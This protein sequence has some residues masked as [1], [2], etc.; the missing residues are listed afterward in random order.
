MRPMRRVEWVFPVAATLSLLAA[1]FIVSRGKSLW[2]DEVYTYYGLAHHSFGEFARSFSTNINATPPLY[3]FVTWGLLK[4]LPLSSL[5]LRLLSS[6]ACGAA[7]ALIWRVLRKHSG[8]FVA[9]VSASTACLASGLF[10]THNTEARFYGL[11]LALIAWCVFNY[12]LLCTEETPS[13]KRLV[14]NG[15]S[16]ALAVSCTYVAG[17][18]S[19]AILLSLIVRDRMVGVW[20]PKVYSSVL[21]GWLPIPFFLPLIRSQKVGTGWIPRPGPTALFTPF[22]PDID[23]YFV[24]FAL[25]VVA[26]LALVGRSR[27]AGLG[28][29]SSIAGWRP[30][31]VLAM[32]FLAVPYGLLLITWAGFPL[33]L[34][35]YALPSLLGVAILFGLAGSAVF[36][37][38][39]TESNGDA[40]DVP[41]N[42]LKGLEGAV[43]LGL[44]A[45]LILYPLG[46]AFSVHREDSL[47][48]NPYRSVVAGQLAVA[49]SDPQSYF[50]LYYNSHENRRIFY[51]VK[52]A[53]ERDRWTGYN[54]RLNPTT[55][56][57]FLATHPS[58][59]IFTKDPSREWIEGE[60][61][62]R[63]GFQIG[64]AAR[65]VEGKLLSVTQLAPNPAL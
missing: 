53:S 35:R 55:L 64:P 51:V 54:R 10:F 49:T 58:F 4:L 8:F 41:S 32:F 52:T 6:V 57:E 3:F 12:D 22:R 21:A 20:R 34:D 24:L 28:S 27:A 14:V 5:T 42:G 26:A 39:S 13:T 44:L 17:F 62:R 37:A 43:K 48:P 46:R 50:P 36:G 30:L 33:L 60:L 11:Y 56:D 61:R 45:A 31:V 38:T 29:A 19:L 47:T 2:L 15:V 63:G 7:F 25:G 9:S 16:H 59:E 18:Y 23:A 1:T 65:P 40:P